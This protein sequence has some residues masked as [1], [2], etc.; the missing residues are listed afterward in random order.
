MSFLYSKSSYEL[1]KEDKNAI[2]PSIGYSYHMNSEEYQ[3]TLGCSFLHSRGMKLYTWYNLDTKSNGLYAYYIKVF[4]NIFLNI[5]ADYYKNSYYNKYVDALW[6]GGGFFVPMDEF[7]D[8]TV[9]TYKVTVSEDSYKFWDNY[10][11]LTFNLSEKLSISLFN[12]IVIDK[13]DTYPIFSL[14][15][16]Y[17]IIT[18][19]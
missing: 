14:S 12:R 9:K 8:F 7:L 3:K 4:G 2:T 16:S 17:N 15:M 11:G 18:N 5:G 10:L 1:I 6:W 13:Y 19:D